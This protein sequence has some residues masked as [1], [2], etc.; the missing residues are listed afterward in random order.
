MVLP[1]VLTIGI[2]FHVR[3]VAFISHQRA[4][5][6]RKHVTGSNPAH[7][8]SMSKAASPSSKL[9]R[10]TAI[11]AIA[12]F[13][14]PASAVPSRALDPVFTAIGAHR[15]AYVRLDRVCRLV[16]DLEGDIPKER[17]REWFDEDRAAGVGADDDPRWTA[18]LAAQRAAF[19][20]EKKTAWALAQARPSN[21]AAV[22]ALLRYATEYEEEG[23]EWPSLPETEGG[24]E[25]W[26]ITF[27]H[28]L[29]AALE[30]MG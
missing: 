27:H 17:R 19:D 15:A 14:A 5:H 8:V 4:D 9:T 23:C 16:S 24:E 29:A 2:R 6:V 13:G 1:I 21:S 30:A 20:A 11:A 3:P 10:R 12:A 28:S 22:A 25:K 26:M 7:G 18:A